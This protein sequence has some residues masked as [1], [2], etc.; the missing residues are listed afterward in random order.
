[1][2]SSLAKIIERNAVLI[3]DKEISKHNLKGTPVIFHRELK[4]INDPED[5]ISKL[6]KIIDRM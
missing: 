1:M 4:R 5:V 6:H 3:T 2:I